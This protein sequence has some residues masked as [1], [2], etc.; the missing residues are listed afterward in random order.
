M[1]NRTLRIIL[2]AAL[3]GAS[4]PGESAQAQGFPGGRGQDRGA[5]RHPPGN[6]DQADA[7]KRN[8]AATNSGLSEPALAIER[9]LPSLRSDL[10][11]DRTQVD[12]WTA[13]ERNVRDAAQAARARQRR[14]LEQRQAAM[15]GGIDLPP[16]VAFSFLQELGDDDRNRADLLTNIA[17]ALGA[18]TKILDTRQAGMI[19]R[20]V[21]QAVRDPL[22][23][24]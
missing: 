20:R 9:E 13:F 23:T 24:G 2:V 5:N 11:L 8:T 12:A 14:I 15:V 21:V 19:N 3:I 6:G 18:L 1:K 17:Q 4:L 22:G 10:L 16:G 7:A